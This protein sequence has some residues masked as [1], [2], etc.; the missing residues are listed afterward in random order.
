[1]IS[2]SLKPICRDDISKIENYKEAVESKEFWE[3]HLRLELTLDNELAHTKEELI[4][5]GMYYN[6]PYYE[7]IF[8]PRS[9]HMTLHRNA[10]E[11]HKFNK[12]K[13]HKNMERNERL[14][15]RRERKKMEALGQ[16]F[17]EV[18]SCST[19]EPVYSHE[20]Q[21]ILVNKLT[22]IEKLLVILV[23]LECSKSGIEDDNL[24]FEEMRDGNS[25]TVA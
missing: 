24:D 25:D 21:K 16:K 12:T 4:R 13:E 2:R 7:L 15:L 8:L 10:E 18:D 1:M 5:L 17:S 3:C 14:K 23:K 11:T 22:R 20:M 6:R 9:Y 19:I